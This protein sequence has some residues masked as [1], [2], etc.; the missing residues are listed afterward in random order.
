MTSTLA[1]H[2]WI[3]PMGDLLDMHRVA[4]G[5]EAFPSEGRVLI[6][7]RIKHALELQNDPSFDR[8]CAAIRVAE[9]ILRRWRTD[10]IRRWHKNP[11]GLPVPLSSDAAPLEHRWGFA[12]KVSPSGKSLFECWGCD[13]AL[14]PMPSSRTP[15]PGR[16]LSSA[17]SNVCFDVALAVFG[18][19]AYMPDE[20]GLLL[21][22]RTDVV[23]CACCSSV[24]PWAERD[25]IA[26]ERV[27]PACL[28]E[29]WAMV[30]SP[31]HSARAATLGRLPQLCD[32]PPG[33]LPDANERTRP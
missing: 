6:A 3:T 1:Q 13:A 24:G 25:P 10:G 32:L 2:L 14:S 5:N 15:C 31:R 8:Y 33:F 19:A 26:R 23:A 27:C 22:T 30:R 17:A 11:Q 28:K 4:T 20:G 16:A 29:T 21:P 9:R 18:G 7:T 12:Y